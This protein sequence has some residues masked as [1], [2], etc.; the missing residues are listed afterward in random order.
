MLQFFVPCLVAMPGAGSSQFES[1]C[2]GIRG[3]SVGWSELCSLGFGGNITAEYVYEL[4]VR[5]HQTH[6]HWTYAQMLNHTHSQMGEYSAQ[7]THASYV[8]RAQ[9]LN[10]EYKGL[11]RGSNSGP[12]GTECVRATMCNIDAGKIATNYACFACSLLW[13]NAVFVKRAARRTSNATRP[14]SK[15]TNDKYFTPE[16]QAEKAKVC[17]LQCLLHLSLFSHELSSHMTQMSCPS[18]SN[19]RESSHMSPLLT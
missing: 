12:P 11:Y 2:R 16:A 4:E 13:Q 5:P 17:L 9:Q 8:A 7:R 1:A 14:V 15:N 3:A 18:H 6:K 10:D 19:C